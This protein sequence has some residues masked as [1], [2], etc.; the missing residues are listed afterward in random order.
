MFFST[1]TGNWAHDLK[2]FHCTNMYSL[3]FLI[4]Y[5]CIFF[6]FKLIELSV[7]LSILSIYFKELEVLFINLLFV[8]Y[9]INFDFLSF[10]P[11]AFSFLCHFACFLDWKFNF[12]Y[13]KISLI[14][15]FKTMNFYHGF[16]H[17]PSILICNAFI[18]FVEVL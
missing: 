2:H 15:I 6:P 12:F 13:S 14:K 5:F 10:L 1:W 4:L 3:L 11:C 17:I 9:L 16:K 8:F 18:I 7:S